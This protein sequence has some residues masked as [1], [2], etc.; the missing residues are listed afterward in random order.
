LNPYYLEIANIREQCSWV[1]KDK[2]VGT[3]KAISLVRTAVAKAARNEPF[4]PAAI[5][6]YQAGPGDRRRDRRHS[7]G[8]GYC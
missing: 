2:E 8:A 3:A 4:S 7:G 5:E 1:H 6:D